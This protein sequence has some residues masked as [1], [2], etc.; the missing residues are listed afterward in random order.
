MS[1]AVEQ[2]ILDTVTRGGPK[3]SGS[4]RAFRVIPHTTLVHNLYLTNLT[5]LTHIKYEG[6][7]IKN[8]RVSAT[9]SLGRGV[10]GIADVQRR[11]LTPTHDAT[12]IALVFV[13]SPADAATLLTTYII[14]ARFRA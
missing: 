11:S 12:D 9:R 10:R 2:S 6:V 14:A 7:F 13:L 5:A 1:S 3:K 4:N 8:E